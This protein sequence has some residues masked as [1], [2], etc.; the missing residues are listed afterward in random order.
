M[1]SYAS[2]FGFKTET[3]TRATILFG[4]V[5]TVCAIVILLLRRHTLSSKDN[6]RLRWVIWGCLIGLP[7]VVIADLAQYTT[8]GASVW[9]FSPPEDLIGLLYLVNGILC[10]FVFEAIRR[11]RVVNVSIPL[12]R[13]TVLA[14]TM[15]VP[16]LLL[17]REAEHFQEALDVSEWTWFMIAAVFVFVIGQLH[18]G[19][20]ELADRYFNRDID[21]AERDLGEAIRTAKDPRK[22]DHL[23][24]DACSRH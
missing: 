7:A 10:L 12:R 13:V 1:A 6:Q 9:D 5:V 17:H 11:P 14:L 21:K 23:L 24:S 8:V 2:A 18:H 3:L 15:S 4:L 20:V 19:A 16:A 22:I